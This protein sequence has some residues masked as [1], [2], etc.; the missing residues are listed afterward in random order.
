MIILSNTS[1]RSQEALDMLPKYGFDKS[2]FAGAITSGELA[3]ELLGVSDSY[4]G[5][6]VVHCNWLKRGGVPGLRGFGLKCVGRE[7]EVADMILAH[8]TEGLSAADSDGSEVEE[9]KLEELLQVMRDAADKKRVDFVCAN[10]DLVTVHGSELRPMPGMLA[11]EFEKAGGKDVVRLGKPGKVAYDAA[12]DMLRKAGLND[13]KGVLAVG[14]SLMHDILGAADAGIDCLFVAGGIAAQ[15]FGL[16]ADT[17]KAGPTR[18]K[19]DFTVLTKMME[20]EAP[21]LNGRMPTSI[22]PYFRW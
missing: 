17:E 10:P 9:C 11:A 22:I 2:L 8:G 21:Q 15:N 14:D 7:V 4:R 1:R 18:W 12:V 5:K 6:K 19:P 16:Q 3:Y 20:E 13:R